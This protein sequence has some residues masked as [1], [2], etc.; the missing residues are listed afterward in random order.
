ML[1]LAGNVLVVNI[2]LLTVPSPSVVCQKG[3]INSES[4]LHTLCSDFLAL[5]AALRG[6]DPLR[7]AQGA[8]D[9]GRAGRRGGPTAAGPRRVRPTSAP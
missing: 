8:R 1:I 9:G 5:T 7:A 2:W 4:I 6:A 3:L